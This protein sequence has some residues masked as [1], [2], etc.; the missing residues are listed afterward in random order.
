MQSCV[1]DLWRQHPTCSCHDCLTI[2]RDSQVQYS[3]SV[4]S[5]SGQLAHGRVLPDN[6]LILAIPV[7]AHNLIHVLAPQKIADLTACVHKKL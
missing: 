5:Q 2:W 6:D 3:E 7:G 4:S 1:L